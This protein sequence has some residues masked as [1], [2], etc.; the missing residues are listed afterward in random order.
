MLFKKRAEGTTTIK[1]SVPTTDKETTS[2]KT[3]D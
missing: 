2:D 3:T 1:G